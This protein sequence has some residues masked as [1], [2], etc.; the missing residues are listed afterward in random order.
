MVSCMAATYPDITGALVAGGQAT[1]LG[2]AVKGLLVLDGEPIA[3]R[4]LRLFGR[5]F[6]G[7]MVVTNDPSP[8][9]ALGAP[10]VGDRLPGRGAASGIHAAL[11]A[12][13]TPWVFAAACDMPF[14]SE[15]GVALLASK[16]AGAAA[17]LPRWGSRLEPLHALWSKACLPII[18][19]ALSE[20]EPSLMALARLVGARVVEES[21]WRM[22]DPDGRA[23]ANVNTPEDAARLGLTVR[24]ADRARGGRG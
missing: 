5:L 11:A 14:L 4:S 13:G 20:G 9:A 10:L 1:R 2:G 16:R 23:F 6:E 15:Q 12:A 19:Q 24:Y 7:S 17:V 21:E 8:Y 22:I 18:E 3:A